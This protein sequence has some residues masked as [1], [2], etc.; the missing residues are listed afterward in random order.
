MPYLHHPISTCCHLFDGS[1]YF[2]MSY[3]D[4]EGCIHS[5]LV[6]QDIYNS[7]DA[8]LKSQIAKFSS[9]QAQHLRTKNEAFP[10]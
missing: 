4:D 5:C 1:I 9:A 8:T 3:S 2:V 7:A 6:Q 10:I